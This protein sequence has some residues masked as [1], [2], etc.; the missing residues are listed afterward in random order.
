MY[1]KW[2]TVSSETYVNYSGV[3]IMHNIWSIAITG[4]QFD[5]DTVNVL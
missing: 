2:P 4:L 1:L 5:P 3:D